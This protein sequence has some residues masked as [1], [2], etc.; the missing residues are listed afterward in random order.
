MELVSVY[1]CPVYSAPYW[2]APTDRRF[3][4]NKIDGIPE[5]DI[6][7]SAAIEWKSPM[8]FAPKKTVCSDSEWTN[9]TEML[10]PFE[11]PIFSPTKTIAST[12]WKN[13]ALF[14]V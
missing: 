5:K 9:K 14:H 10:Y 1:I 4:A 3:A 13:L 12:G 8:A 7:E 6:V 11:T 2:A